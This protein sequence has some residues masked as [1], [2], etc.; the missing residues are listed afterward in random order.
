MGLFYAWVVLRPDISCLVYP[1]PVAGRLETSSG[2][3]AEGSEEASDRRGVDDFYGLKQY[4]PGDPIGRISW[5][6][7]SRGQGVFTKD[8]SGDDSGSVMLNYDAIKAE[9]VEFKLSRLTD[10]VLK[11]HKM[12]TEYGLTIPGFTIAPGAGERHKHKCLRALAV[13]GLDESHENNE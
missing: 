11:A 7:L 13:F 9:D 10:M 3:W 12:N 8:F 1:K 4:Q 6:S 2:Q 5:K